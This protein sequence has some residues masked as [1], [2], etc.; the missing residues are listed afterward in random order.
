M[1]KTTFFLVCE[2]AATNRIRNDGK[3]GDLWDKWRLGQKH[4][5]A[6]LLQFLTCVL[7]IKKFLCSFR[8]CVLGLQRA[9]TVKPNCASG[10]CPLP[11]LAGGPINQGIHRLS[12]LCLRARGSGPPRSKSEF[13]Q[14]KCIHQLRRVAASRLS[15]RWVRCTL[16]LGLCVAL[17]AWEGVR[18][19]S[20]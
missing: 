7:N 3:S 4:R 19:T 11:I 2:C 5:V 10:D 1:C 9:L 16:P 14:H 18:G 13:L 12:H 6:S 20:F 8:L 15:D 17:S